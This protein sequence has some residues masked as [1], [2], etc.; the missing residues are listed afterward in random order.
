MQTI[1]YGSNCTAVSAVPDDT[2]SFVGWSDNSSDNPRTDT[3][4]TADISVIANFTLITTHDPVAVDDTVTVSPSQ[5]VVINVLE[6]DSDPDG[7]AISVTAISVAPSE[8]DAVISDAG[9]TVTYTASTR[10]RNNHL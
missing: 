6:N 4:I 7:D 10:W 5:S 9:T 8:G 1:N 3:N 2:Y